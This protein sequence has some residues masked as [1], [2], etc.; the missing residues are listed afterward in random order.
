RLRCT[1]RARRRPPTHLLDR[2][3]WA[4]LRALEVAPASR[5]TAGARRGIGS[6]RHADGCALS[7]LEIGLQ[8]I[9]PWPYRAGLAARRPGRLQT[10][11]ASLAC[12][13]PLAV[14]RP[15]RPGD[16]GTFLRVPP[17]CIG[18]TTKRLTAH[19]VHAVL[20]HTAHRRRSPP[21]FGVARQAL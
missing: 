20:P 9:Q 19:T 21:T 10:A 7:P 18:D 17:N 1:S 2:P 8:A 15:G 16:P 5:F 4:A 13:C 12:S 6:R 11:T 3:H 14:S